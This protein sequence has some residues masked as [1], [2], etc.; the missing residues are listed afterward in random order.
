MPETGFFPVLEGL[1]LRQ[2]IQSR[3]ASGME[4]T[5]PVSSEDTKPYACIACVQRKVK[6]DKRVPCLSCTRSRLQCRYRSTPPPQRRKRKLESSS[7]T[8][9]EKLRA[10]ELILRDAGLPFESFVESNDGE[11]DHDVIGVEATESLPPRSSPIAN[12]SVASSS[13]AK[14]PPCRRRGLLVPEH[15]GKRYYDHGMMAMLG[16]EVR[17]ITYL[18]SC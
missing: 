15:G 5:V 13:T 9:L 11:D 6:C 10:H 4:T 18:H 17:A 3:K 8:L 7:Q 14:K 12:A 1:I 2:S 16:Q